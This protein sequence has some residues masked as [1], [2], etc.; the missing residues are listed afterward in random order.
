MDDRVDRFLHIF[1]GVVDDLVIDAF[2]HRFLE[3]GH[4][5]LDVGRQLQRVCAGGF[6]NGDTDGLLVVEQAAQGVV[7]R[8]HLHA[9]DV[10]EAGDGAIGAGLDDDV[11]EIVLGLEAA[12]GVDRQLQHRARQVG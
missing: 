8:A 10:A 5:L 3:F 9:G 4:R 12:L 2:R 7:R 11:A 6:K 1:G